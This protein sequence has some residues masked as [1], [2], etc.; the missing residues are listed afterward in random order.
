MLSAPLNSTFRM[1]Q[2]RP[3]IRRAR[4]KNEHPTFVFSIPDVFHPVHFW[5]PYSHGNT[6]NPD[7]PIGKQ[8]RG[9]FRVTQ[10]KN[11]GVF[12]LGPIAL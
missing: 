8:L 4:V 6:A 9:F 2:I 11:N 3:C 7:S 12:H 5:I 1:G 10:N